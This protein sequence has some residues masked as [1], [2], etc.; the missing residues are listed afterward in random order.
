MTDLSMMTERA[1][2]RIAMKKQAMQPAGGPPMDPAMG[3]A[4]V[5]PA[6]GGAPVDPAMGAAPP[7]MVR[8]EAGENA[9]G[10]PAGARR[11]RRRF[12]S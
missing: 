2:E 12:A 6:M 1:I 7:A 10:A 8:S 11:D 3:G 5:D 4:P 9:R